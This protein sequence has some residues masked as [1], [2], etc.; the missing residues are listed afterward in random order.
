MVRDGS[1][2][3]STPQ[4][5]AF[6]SG[7][8]DFPFSATSVKRNE[9]HFQKKNKK[10][11]AIRPT[12]AADE[13][14]EKMALRSVFTNFDL[15]SNNCTACNSVQQRATACNCVH[16][17]L[18]YTGPDSFSFV[19]YSFLRFSSSTITSST[20]HFHCNELLSWQYFSTIFFRHLFPSQVPT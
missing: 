7:G 1:E 4:R 17:S 16:R 10:I 18:C 15:V 8:D 20:R 11:N 14:V 2:C 5:P 13:N 6:A 9:F 3:C 19:F 12:D